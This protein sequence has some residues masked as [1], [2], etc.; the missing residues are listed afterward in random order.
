MTL[1]VSI[2]VG[3]ASA[4][5]IEGANERGP[6]WIVDTPGN[7][8]VVEPLWT[9]PRF[10]PDRLT[11]F[12]AD[13]HEPQ[14]AA[15]GILDTVDLHHPKWTSIEIVGVKRTAGLDEALANLGSGRVTVAADRVTY[16]RA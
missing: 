5:A 2:V 15:E 9:E 13:P 6:S 3:Q 12:R 10:K 4:V 16:T 7:R 14:A 1:V 11:L 8:T